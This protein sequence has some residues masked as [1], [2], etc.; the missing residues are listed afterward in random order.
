MVNSVGKN[1]TNIGICPPDIVLK[2]ALLSYTEEQLNWKEIQ[3]RLT[4]EFGYT[5]GCTLIFQKMKY[6]NVGNTSQKNAKVIPKEV[7]RSLVLEEVEND[8]N[9]Q[10]SP[11]AI[12]DKLAKNHA[13]VP[14]DFVQQVMKKE[15]PDGAC[16]RAPGNRF[17]RIPC[18]HHFVIGPYQ[19]IHADG[20]EKFLSKALCI[21]PVGFDIHGFWQHVEAIQELVV[22]PN[23]RHADTIG[24]LH[25]DMIVEAGYK[26]PVQMTVDK[27]SETGEMFTQQ[28]ALQKIFGS[29]DLQ[30]HSA[31]MALKST[32]NI[33]IEEII[34]EGRTNS[35][36]NPSNSLHC[37]LFQWL[38]P[39]IVQHVLDSYVQYWNRHQ[40][41]RQGESTMP[42]GAT[43]NQVM[44]CPE[45]YGLRDIGIYVTPEAIQELHQCLPNCKE[46]FHWVN[47]EF[48]CLAQATYDAIGRPSLEGSSAV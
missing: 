9:K 34:E 17:G 1:G 15:D 23:A 38:W 27:G 29:L 28:E 45:D 41:Y 40:V 7:L 4:K 43:P 24:H 30:E 26:M 42:S 11:V 48:E 44:I 22:V 39:K 31:F 5:S 8:V 13:A 25:L 16:Q 32:H 12:Q 14:Q 37:D 18:G 35:M 46:V 6:L 21:G 3:S 33:I 10:N 2:P 19:E 20:H 36:F 47:D